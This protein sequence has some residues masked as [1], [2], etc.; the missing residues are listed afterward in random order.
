M[1]SFVT[2]L[3][4]RAFADL[5]H[6][7]LSRIFAEGHAQVDVSSWMGARLVESL[8]PSSVIRFQIHLL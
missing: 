3:V 4:N 7:P 1:I 2:T 5:L 6:H 8:Q